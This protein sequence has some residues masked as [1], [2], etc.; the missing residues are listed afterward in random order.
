[1]NESQN[2]KPK[3]DYIVDE[4]QMYPHS[5]DHK[6]K[7]DSRYDPSTYISIQTK[8]NY[9]SQYE[10]KYISKIVSEGWVALKKVDDILIFP[11][12]R[13][14]KYR[15]NGNSLS[16][17]PEGTFRSGGWLIGKND[18]DNNYILYKGYN[19]AVFSLQIKDL[20]EIYIKSPKREISIFKKPD[21]NFK[22]IYPVTLPDPETK[23]DIIVY[24]AKDKY[25][26]DRFM[27]SIKYRKALALGKWDWSAVFNEKI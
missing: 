20:L 13:A 21:L 27:N 4:L 6:T 16:G 23:Q 1:M 10:K 17:A 14:F 12:G 25:H 9:D 7:H 19:G 15:L 3:A 8:V 2:I 26:Q 11:K 22:T 24:Y 5:I 18:N